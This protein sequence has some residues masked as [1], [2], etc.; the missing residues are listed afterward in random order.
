[1]K[2]KKIM[3]KLFDYDNH[4][5]HTGVDLYDPNIERVTIKVI[6]GD[7]IALVDYTNGARSIYDSSDCRK[8]DFKDNEYVLLDRENGIDIIEDFLHR[9][10]SYDIDQGLTEIPKYY[11]ICLTRRKANDYK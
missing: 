4:I 2:K 10:N 1:M 3:L 9:E 6:T 7:E 8:Y 5:T 11:I